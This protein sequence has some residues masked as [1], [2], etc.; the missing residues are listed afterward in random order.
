MTAR[1]FGEIDIGRCSSGAV[2]QT[3]PSL[4]TS[5]AFAAHPSRPHC[6]RAR[7][8]TNINMLTEAL[9]LSALAMGAM[10]QMTTTAS[11]P[12]EAETT[13]TA[14]MGSMTSGFAGSIVSANPCDTTLALQ[15]TAFENPICAAASDVTVRRPLSL[16]ALRFYADIHSNSSLSPLD[17]PHTMSCMPLKPRD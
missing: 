14:L 9:T 15:C 10:A 7:R 8:R 3:F 1:A 13:I 6:Y 4:K 2:V 17:R 12:A 16:P 5:I 11:P